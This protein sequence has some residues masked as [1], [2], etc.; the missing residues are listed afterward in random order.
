MRS[1]LIALAL[2]A[3]A[4]L[5]HAHAKQTGI[6]SGL[7][8]GSDAAETYE[9]LQQKCQSVSTFTELSVRF[10][11]AA[12]TETHMVCEGYQGKPIQF[13]RVTAVVADD[14]LVHVQTIGITKASVTSALGEPDGTYLGMHYFNKG[15]VWFDETDGRLTWL[16]ENALHPNLFVW[17]NPRLEQ[18]EKNAVSHSTLIP[19][20][21]DFSASFDELK[22]RFEAECPVTEVQNIENIWLPNKPGKQ[23]QIN[24]FGFPFAGF[25]RKFEAVFGDGKLEV[26]WVLTG[27]PEESRLS[28][29]LGNDWGQPSIENESWEVFGDGRISLYKDKPEF[30]ILSDDM[31]PLYLE[32][33][34]AN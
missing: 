22:P 25:E 16:A 7:S 15:A 14:Q 34:E 30:L 26:I 11:L 27:K 33:F 28:D 31:I 8:M 23:V 18:A 9:L 13:D 4:W 6:V 2:L 17:T 10:P 20:L 19:G 3:S 24:C 32:Q 5:S 21:L 1:S 29:L 12:D